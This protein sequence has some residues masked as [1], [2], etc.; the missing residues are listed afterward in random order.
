ME[1]LA[2]VTGNS[3]ADPTDLAGRFSPVSNG[4]RDRVSS[5]QELRALVATDVLSEGQ[6]LQ[7]AHIVVNYDLPWAIIRLIQRAGRVDRIGQQ[8]PE[9]LSYTFWPAEGVERLIRLRARLRQRLGENA[10]VV[11]SDEAFF[12]DDDGERPL[13]DLYH[14]TPGV[15]DEEPDGDIDLVSHAY[16]IWQN[17]TDAN[18]GLAA[19]VERLPGM[20]NATKAH[21]SAGAEDVAGPPGAGTLVVGPPGVLVYM[22]T[23]TGQSALAWLDETGKSVTESQF[24]ILR[25]ARCALDEPPRPRQDNHHDLEAAA[26]RHMLRER[27]SVAGGQLGRPSGAR[28]KTYVRLTAYAERQRSTLWNGLP[29]I[30]TLNR[31]IDQIYQYPLRE[32]ARERLNRQLRSEVTDE[33]LVDL[34]VL[35]FEDDMLCLVQ[36]ET[37]AGE[38]QIICS[39]G[40]VTVEDEPTP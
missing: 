15:L 7:D 32:S 2:G 11:G 37:T 3:A 31:A 5:D 25:A 4:K 10:E 26:V 40:L 29:R 12:E 34:V 28:F 1:K 23:D 8:S 35:M 13:V 18:P 16:Q 19:Q 17:A 39:L 36:E 20:V 33:Q 21:P 9:I 30:Q 6:N 14:E 38:P 22:K 27:T 24:A